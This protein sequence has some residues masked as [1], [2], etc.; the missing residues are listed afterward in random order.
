MTPDELKRYPL[1][2]PSERFEFE[3]FRWGL[4]SGFALGLATGLIIT[5]V[6]AWVFA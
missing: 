3:A 4:G 6:A 2:H 1:I 5:M